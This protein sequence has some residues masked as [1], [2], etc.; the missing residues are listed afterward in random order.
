MDNQQKRRFNSQRKNSVFSG[1]KYK[2]K[3]NAYYT[4]KECTQKNIMGGTLVVLDNGKYNQFPL[5]ILLQLCT[6]F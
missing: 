2:Y 4:P 6:L 3:K 1:K 5:F